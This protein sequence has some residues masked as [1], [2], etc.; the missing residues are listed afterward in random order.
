MERWNFVEISM[1]TLSFDRFQSVHLFAA[2]KESSWWF[3]LP[4]VKINFGRQNISIPRILFG[5]LTLLVSPIFGYWIFRAGARISKNLV[6]LIGEISRL[7][8]RT[9]GS[10]TFTRVKIPLNEKY[11]AANLYDYMFLVRLP[12]KLSET[13]I[14]Y[15]PQSV[16]VRARWKLKN[17]AFQIS[18]K[19]AAFAAIFRTACIAF[20]LS[21]ILQTIA[22]V[23]KRN[24]YTILYREDRNLYA[25]AKSKWVIILMNNN[26]QRVQ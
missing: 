3:L 26:V 2:T 4:V 16:C 24:L 1:A 14:R 13:C 11:S 6:L 7:F 9:R 25:L 19:E 21:F 17:I 18:T 20:K 12:D 10:L 15:I 8:L 23:W 22:Y 5:I